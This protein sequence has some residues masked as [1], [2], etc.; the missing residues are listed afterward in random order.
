MKFEKSY[1]LPF[2]R[3]RV[4]AAWTSSD[5]VIPPATRMDI[6][7]VV[8]GH[9]RLFMDTPEFS[10]RNEGVFLAVEPPSRLK[11]TWEWDSDGKVTD[12]TVEFASDGDGCKVRVK[13]AGFAEKDSFDMHAAGWDSYISGL[14]DYLAD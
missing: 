6:E 9:Y 1:H 8:G 3:D 2:S 11:Y 13:H 10:T 4:Y 14:T 7:P 12:I 5:T